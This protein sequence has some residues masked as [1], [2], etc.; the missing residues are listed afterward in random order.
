MTKV[1]KAIV[2]AYHWSDKTNLYMAYGSVSAKKVEAWNHCKELCEQ[3]N[4]WGLK[5]IGANSFFFSA[6]FMFEEEGVTKLMYITHGGAREIEV[7][8]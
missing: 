2:D 8:K 6:G 3:K 1:N 7:K 5:V 4:G